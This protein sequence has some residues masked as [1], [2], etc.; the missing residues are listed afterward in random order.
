MEIGSATEVKGYQGQTRSNAEMEAEWK[1]SPTQWNE[2]GIRYWY[3]WRTKVR[4]RNELDYGAVHNKS[5]TWGQK[6]RSSDGEWAWNGQINEV[7]RDSGVELVGGWGVR[8][9]DEAQ[10]KPWSLTLDGLTHHEIIWEHER[11]RV[12]HRVKHDTQPIIKTAA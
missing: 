1:T 5:V 4:N 7:W 2:G 10:V 9:D 8:R 3:P 12:K 11:M 6:F